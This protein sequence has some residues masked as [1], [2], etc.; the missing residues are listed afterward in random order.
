MEVLTLS[1]EL[2][3]ADKGFAGVLRA[4]MMTNTQRVNL[5]NRSVVEYKPSEVD[6]FFDPVEEQCNRGTGNLLIP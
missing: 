2:E 4:M 1:N 3:R 6:A 5:M